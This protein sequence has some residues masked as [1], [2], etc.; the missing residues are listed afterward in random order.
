MY[1]QSKFAGFIPRKKNVLS[2]PIAPPH[3]PF[4]SLF[5]D[6]GNGMAVKSRKTN[7]SLASNFTSIF[8]ATQK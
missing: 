2:I 1:L 5:P 3:Q 8:F 7:L 6:I 4:L